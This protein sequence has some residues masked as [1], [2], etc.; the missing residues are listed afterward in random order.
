[1]NTLKRSLCLAVLVASTAMAQRPGNR[2][3]GYDPAKEVTVSGT[4]DEV[5]TPARGLHL[6]L[7]AA[8]AVH[9]IALGPKAWVEK[10]G[11]TFAKGDS[12]QITGSRMTMRG[13]DVIVAREAVK[14]GKTLTL[15]D[16]SGQPKWSGSGRRKQ[17]VN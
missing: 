9:E 7:K 10:Q 12:V 1:M 3:R 13:K 5:A 16:A 17:Q 11:F 2:Q 6:A 14:D 15:R 4:V 8:D